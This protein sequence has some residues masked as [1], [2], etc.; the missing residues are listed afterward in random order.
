MA[1]PSK[2]A[3]RLAF[4]IGQRCQIRIRRTERVNTTVSLAQTSETQQP[5]DEQFIA[6]YRDLIPAGKAYFFVFD[7]N[8]DV[9]L[10]ETSSVLEIT[11]LDRKA[12]GER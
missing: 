5:Y 12:G 4:L 6:I 3:E 7:V 11:V 2:V 1:K 8:G 10:F 9:R